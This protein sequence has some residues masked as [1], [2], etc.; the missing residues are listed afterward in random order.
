MAC[1]VDFVFK[2]EGR[3]AVLSKLVPRSGKEVLNAIAELEPRVST[4]L[5]RLL[6]DFFKAVTRSF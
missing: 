5:R 3:K 2:G 6:V 4:M 1:C